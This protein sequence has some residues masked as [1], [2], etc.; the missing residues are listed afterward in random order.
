MKILVIDND[1][2]ESINLSDYLIRQGHRCNYA[3]TIKDGLFLIE[4]YQYDIIFLESK[5]VG[6]CLD[7]EGLEC[8]CRSAKTSGSKTI[9]LTST[10]FTDE[11]IQILLQ[12]GIQ[13][14]ISKHVRWNNL[15]EIIESIDAMND[16][17]ATNLPKNLS[18]ENLKRY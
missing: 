16:I 17:C 10:S 5:G 18:V 8:I 6:E 3:S 15:L 13:S 14:V 12:K 4:N 11:E 1:M 2:E 7:I 9:L